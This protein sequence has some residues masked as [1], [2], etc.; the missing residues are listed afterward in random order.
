[1]TLALPLLSRIDR[2]RALTG[3]SDWTVGRRSPLVDPRLVGRV[4]RGEAALRLADRLD[5]WLAA[6]IARLEAGAPH[7]ANISMSPPREEINAVGT[8]D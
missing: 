1:M 4:R 7:A 5:G 6:E 3:V 2:Y 8:R